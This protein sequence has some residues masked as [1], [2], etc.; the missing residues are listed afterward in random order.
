MP[1]P[2]LGEDDLGREDR[3]SDARPDVIEQVADLLESAATWLRQEVREIVRTKVILPLQ[4]LGL[5]L[6][7]AQAAGCLMVVGLLWI[8]VA[9]VILVGVWFHGRGLSWPAAYGV[10]FMII[11]GVAVIG[12]AVFIAIKTRWMQK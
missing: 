11:G 4:R 7:A 12:S 9:A 6:A 2:G 5:T 8:E 1:E 3:D 10:T